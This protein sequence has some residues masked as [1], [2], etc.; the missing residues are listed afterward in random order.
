MTPEA[1]RAMRT[2]LAFDLGGGEPDYQ[3]ARQALGRLQELEQ[4]KPSIGEVTRKGLAAGVAGTGASLLGRA[5]TGDIS[6]PFVEGMKGMRP[7]WRGVAKGVG[8]GLLGL[9]RDIAG[10]AATSAAFGTSLPFLSRALDRRA[11]QARLKDYL[12]ERPRSRLRRS[13]SEYLGV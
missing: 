9:G 10:T 5:I 11:E 8:R 3:Q 12:E 4:T 13:A 7:G 1:F 6:K 2:K